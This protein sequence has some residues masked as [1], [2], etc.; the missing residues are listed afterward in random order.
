MFEHAVEI[1]CTLTKKVA[2]FS[3]MAFTRMRAVTK[4][5]RRQQMPFFTG[6]RLLEVLTD[7]GSHST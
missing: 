3:S 5:A 7:T 4:N 2:I 1:I 6:T